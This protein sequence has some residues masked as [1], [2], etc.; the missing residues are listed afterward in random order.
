MGHGCA[1]EWRSFATDVASRVE[2]RL[3]PKFELPRTDPRSIPGSSLDMATLGEDTGPHEVARRLA[4]VADAYEAWIDEK[5]QEA[6]R[7]PQ[8]VR[9]TADDHLRHCRETLARLRDGIEL[10]TSNSDARAAFAFANRAMLLQRSHTEWSE[11]RRRDAASSAPSP[12]L[13]GE[14]RPFQIAFILLCLRGI[15]DPQRRPDD[16]RSALVSDRRREDRGV[17]R[18]AAFTL[19]ASTPAGRRS[20]CARMPAS[21][22]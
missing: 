7:L 20:R 12:A 14:W 11:S 1:V 17:P 16:R 4:P 15:V 9:G 13:Q 21:P 6:A 19:A 8:S 18:A 3:I 2:T 5:T 10:L 22:C